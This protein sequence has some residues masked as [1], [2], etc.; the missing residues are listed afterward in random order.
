MIL[1]INSCTEPYFNMA[2]E[3]YLMNTSKEPAV[4]LWRNDRAVIIGKNQNAE[5]TVNFDYTQKNGIA[6]VRR[7]TG[8][9]AVFHDLGNVNYTFILPKAISPDDFSEFSRPVLDALDGIGIKAECSGRN[10][11]TVNEKK[12]SG[13]ARCE[14][15]G[16]AGD[17][18]M[19][20]G[21]LLF[22]ADMGELAAALKTDE[23]KVRSKGI[24]SVSA[25]VANI[26]EL[27]PE[28]HRAMTVSD[29]IRYLENYFENAG[30]Q[31]SEL[32]DDDK[33]A[34]SALAD[35]KYRTERWLMRAG[36]SD[37]DVVRK[38]RYP[39]GT[40]SV[41]LSC[42][43]GKVGEKATINAARVEGD[44]FGDEDVSR[45]ES[46]LVGTEFSRNAVMHALENAD[47][48]KCIRGAVAEDIASLIF[49]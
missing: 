8:G 10:D 20:H 49:G 23:A 34:I 28:A 30:A 14:Y 11:L 41:S 18:I 43:A 24:K 26:K 32:S 6:V 19:H 47:I 39:F 27:L 4:M 35:G 12:I 7:L 2:C 3:E 16:N 36:A 40:V 22:S 13:T 38:N 25:R 37:F 42:K 1:I 31:K 48:G 44:F 33:A 45:L 46:A 17:V 15:H 9:G 29:F 5:E 21:T